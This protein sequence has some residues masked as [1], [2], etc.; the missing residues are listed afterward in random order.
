MKLNNIPLRLDD[1]IVDIADIKTV[2][3]AD[4]NDVGKMGY[5][6]NSIHLFENLK[7]SNG[8]KY[9][10]LIY[11]SDLDYGGD[12]SDKCFVCS[13]QWAYRYFIPEDALKP[14]EKKYRAFSLN[15]FLE[16]F[17]IGEALYIRFK[18]DKAER[19]VVFT[20]YSIPPHKDEGNDTESVCLTGIEHHKSVVC[21]GMREYYLATLFDCYEYF[22]G[23][24]WQ[25]FGI[26][27]EE[28]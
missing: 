26:E 23:K 6:A 12:K 3:T 15:E 16:R 19:V 11:L 14:V 20:E 28:K 4:E 27:V 24:E 25:P 10:K 18:R 2:I 7:G 21:L 9:G 8:I 17:K 13:N 5:F 1:R 22:D